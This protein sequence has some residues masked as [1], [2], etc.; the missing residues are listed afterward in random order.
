M[1]ITYAFVI[2][3]LKGTFVLNSFTNYKEIL[4]AMFLTGCQYI[5]LEDLGAIVYECPPEF[6][7]LFNSNS[8][9]S[10]CCPKGEIN[11]RIED[12]YGCQCTF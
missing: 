11:I 1:N 3:L 12:Y 9:K 6:V 10:G 4:M 2:L 5:V 7:G 8:V